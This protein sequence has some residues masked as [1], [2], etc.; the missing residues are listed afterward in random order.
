MSFLWFIQ[1]ILIWFLWQISEAD[2]TLV[3]EMEKLSLKGHIE[4]NCN[5][6]QVCLYIVPPLESIE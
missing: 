2:L 1:H 6:I 5:Q 4:V 3:S